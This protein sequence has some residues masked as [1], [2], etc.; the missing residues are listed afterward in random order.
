MAISDNDVLEHSARSTLNLYLQYT[1]NI[2]H[3]YTKE[4]RN[5][6]D[7]DFWM[8]HFALVAWPKGS[9]MGLKGT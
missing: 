4:H 6:E 5:R 7:E 9:P 2:L 8:S 1:V 3:I